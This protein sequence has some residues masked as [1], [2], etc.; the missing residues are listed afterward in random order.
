VTGTAVASDVLYEL[1]EIFVPE[2][3][4]QLISRQPPIVLTS[5]ASSGKGRREREREQ[6]RG[7]DSRAESV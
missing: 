6:Q 4:I 3:F 2:A 5:W 1:D 7:D